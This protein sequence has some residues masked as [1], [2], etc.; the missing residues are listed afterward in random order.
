MQVQ[1]H[2]TVDSA[3]PPDDDHPYRTGVWRPQVTEYDAWD[4][5]VVEGEIPAD[6]NGVYLRNTE[7]AL[8]EPI[9]R[10]HPFDGDSLMHA[11]SFEA[12]EARYTSRFVRTDGFLAEQ[13]AARSLWAGITEHPSNAVADHGSGARTMMKDN[14]STDVIVHRGQALA[15][16]YQCGEFWAMDPR[17]LEPQ[18][19]TDW[20]GPAARPEWGRGFPTE[21][22]SAHP[23]VD[24]HTGDLLFFNYSA[25]APFMHYGVV[26]RNGD[27]VTYEDIPL[28]GPRLPHDMAFTENWSILNDLPLYWE[29]KALADGWYS[30][31]FNRDLPSRFA[32]IPRHGTTDDIRWFEADPTFVLH[33]TNAYEDGDEVVL[34][35]FFQHNPTARG[36]DRAAGQHKGFETLDMN[37]LQARA[38]RWR[39]NLATG[40]CREESLSDRCLEFPMINGRHAGRRHR[41]SYEARCTHGLFAFDALV[42]RDNELGT[43]ELV[44]FPDGTFVSE[45]IMAPR[46]GSTAEDDGYLVTFSSDL[47]NDVSECV[48]LD[49]AS[50]S[51]GPVARIRL[52]ER[53]SSGTHST[54]APLEDLAAFT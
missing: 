53:I 45:T 41:Y 19:R 25:D 51:S 26:D 30:N 23:K 49:A 39:F 32:L 31:T 34:D 6:L 40:E 42:K 36:A 3:L 7:T 38:H 44:E 9:K 12:G 17:T 27:L 33:W 43:E 14:G 18:G 54:W 2:N 5:D 28:P 48:V 50:P 52:P 11:M 47:V 46:A 8:F 21:G 13:Q 4:L 1:I 15:S 16:F 35:G 37:V 20:S 10:Y 24:E 29:P 22:V